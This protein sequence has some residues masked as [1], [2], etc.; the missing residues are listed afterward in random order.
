MWGGQFEAFYSSPEGGKILS[1]SELKQ[2]G[3]SVYFEFERFETKGAGKGR[4]IVLTP[5]PKGKAAAS[6]ELVTLDRKAKRAVFENPKKDYPTRIVYHRVAGDRLE[7][8]LSDPHGKSGKTETFKLKRTKHE[9]APGREA[10]AD[11][12]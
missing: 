9:K 12:S 8:T 5:H 6:F 2:G 10:G 4:G 7:I 3:K 1:F 11:E